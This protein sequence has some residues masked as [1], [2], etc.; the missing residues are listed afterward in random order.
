VAD[1]L[2]PLNLCI[3]FALMIQ[4]ILKN[5]KYKKILAF[6]LIPIIMI[7]CNFLIDISEPR[8]K[9]TTF[10]KLLKRTEPRETPYRAKIVLEKIYNKYVKDE[11]DDFTD[12][13]S[14]IKSKTPKDSIFITP[15]IEYEFALKAQRAQVVTY[16]CVPV[17]KNLFAW[18][19]RMEDLN[20]GKFAQQG[21]GW[22]YRELK[23]NYPELTENEIWAMKNKYGADYVLTTNKGYSGFNIIYQNNTYTLYKIT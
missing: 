1:G 22:M 4:T 8:Q 13:S 15:P 5:I 16:K 10:K 7:T 19:Q 6:S 20:G 12:A 23:N 9:Y 2:L 18:K 17:G 14:W 3:G 11:I 21:K